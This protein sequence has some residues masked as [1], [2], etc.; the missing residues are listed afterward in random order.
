MK[1]RDKTQNTIDTKGDGK[2]I[3]QNVKES[4]V[5]IERVIKVEGNNNIIIQD[6]G[7]SKITI[8]EKEY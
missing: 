6:S 1:K 8:E 3:I 4:T 5:E 2:V 7:S